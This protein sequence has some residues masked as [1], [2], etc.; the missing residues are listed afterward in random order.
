MPRGILAYKVKISRHQQNLG[1]MLFLKPSI[2][3]IAHMC[4]KRNDNESC[5]KRLTTGKLTS[6][7]FGAS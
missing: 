6:S 5:S 1:Q 7:V 2:S 3:L 4:M